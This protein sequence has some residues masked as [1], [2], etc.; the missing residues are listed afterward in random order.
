MWARSLRKKAIASKLGFATARRFLAQGVY[1]R[2]HAPWR[3]PE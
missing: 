2:L 3:L 1:S